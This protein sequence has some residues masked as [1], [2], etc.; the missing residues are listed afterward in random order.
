MYGRRLRPPLLLHD[1]AHVVRRLRAG[2][3]REEVMQSQ[4]YPVVGAPRREPDF[5]DGQ[6]AQSVKNASLFPVELDELYRSHHGLVRI[7]LHRNQQTCPKHGA[8]PHA[9]RR[10]ALSTL[11]SARLLL[12][13]RRSRLLRSTEY[14]TVLIS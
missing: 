7:S 1:G 5:M 10:P 4:L 12:G 8:A 9:A 3:S 14:S 13:P 6:C 2:P 11:A